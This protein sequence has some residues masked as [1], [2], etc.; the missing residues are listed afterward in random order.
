MQQG[1]ARMPGFSRIFTSIFTDFRDFP[2]FSSKAGRSRSVQKRIHFLFAVLFLCGGSLSLAFAQNSSSHGSFPD[3]PVV[4]IPSQELRGVANAIRSNPSPAPVSKETPYQDF[5]RQNRMIQPVSHNTPYPPE[6]ISREENS[7]RKKSIAFAEAPEKVPPVPVG[8]NRF[9]EMEPKT[10][11]IRKESTDS[12]LKSE[13]IP[14]R[15]RPLQNRSGSP[16]PLPREKQTRPIQPA[17]YGGL[18]EMERFEN[19]ELLLDSETLEDQEDGYS[20]IKENKAASEKFSAPRESVVRS[21]DLRRGEKESEII[22]ESNSTYSSYEKPGDLEEDF[23]E[24]YDEESWE[25]EIREEG[26]AE[27]SGSFSD[28]FD[29][30]LGGTASIMDKELIGPKEKIEEGKMKIASFDFMPVV[31]VL[32]SLSLVLGAFFLFMFFL[33]KVGPK[34]GG[35]L[36]REALESIGR[37]ALNPKLQLNLIRLG[38]RLILVAITQDGVV[39]PISEIDNP[40]EVAQILAM[41]RKLDP[42]SSLAQFQ[43]V[44]NEF[45]EE[46]APGGFF[47]TNDP[48]RKKQSAPSLSSLLSGG[49]Q[50]PNQRKGGYYA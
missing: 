22:S 45:A 34:T 44:L 39:E 40:D 8:T 42:N 33:K 13:V 17:R 41:C 35:N 47:G 21:K 7:T 25:S 48:K 38:N 15:T 49:L 11:P 18:D 30:S 14:P 26:I 1:G 4:S 37:F 31:S 16:T 50:N 24:N 6:E 10:R 2:E 43:S 3:I 29:Y 19:L 20:G 27:N 9:T 36:P 32:G 23:V 28:R 12:L 5:V 46:K